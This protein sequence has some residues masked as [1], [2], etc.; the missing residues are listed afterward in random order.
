MR[1]EQRKLPRVGRLQQ[2]PSSQSIHATPVG[3]K[4]GRFGN[5]SPQ[6]APSC[7]LPST[8]AVAE[9]L[10]RYCYVIIPQFPATFL[11]SLSLS[12]FMQSP[13]TDGRFRPSVVFPLNDS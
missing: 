9:L 5:G 7:F 10:L 13:R 4:G 3:D 1:H 2:L 8:L 6:P 11:S 12:L